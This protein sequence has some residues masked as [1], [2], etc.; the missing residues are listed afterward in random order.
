[1][2]IQSRVLT[3]IPMSAITGMGTKLRILHGIL[4]MCMRGYG[5]EE[6][7]VVRDNSF[8]LPS[9]LHLFTHITSFYYLSSCSL[10]SHSI[11]CNPRGNKVT[12]CSRSISQSAQFKG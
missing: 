2:V 7:S 12:E 9:I 6:G 8:S 4:C 3:H 11:R 5:I 10:K 1:M